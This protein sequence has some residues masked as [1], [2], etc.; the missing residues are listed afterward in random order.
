MSK[1]ER[2][3]LRFVTNLAKGNVAM[4]IKFDKNDVVMVVEDDEKN[5]FRRSKLGR[6]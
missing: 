3:V 6:H 1:N 4:G 5:G 2:I